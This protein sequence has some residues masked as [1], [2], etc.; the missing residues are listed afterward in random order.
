MQVW[1]KKLFLFAHFVGRGDSRGKCT[2]ADV[3]ITD[4]R[5]TR[6]QMRVKENSLNRLILC[7]RTPLRLVLLTH[8]RYAHSYNA[9]RRT[10]C[11]ILSGV[12]Y[13]YWT[14]HWI[15]TGVPHFVQVLT[16]SGTMAEQH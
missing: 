1:K 5:H 4:Q 10:H 15:Y 7:R 3:Q 16:G 2:G 12:F 11:R 13:V 14:M 9:R 8:A 6:A